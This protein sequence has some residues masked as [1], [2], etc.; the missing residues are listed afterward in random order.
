MGQEV[1]TGKEIHFELICSL[2]WVICYTTPMNKIF[3]TVPIP[4]TDFFLIGGVSSVG[5]CVEEG[6][7]FFAR[8][9]ANKKKRER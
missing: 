5:L 8:R 1:G 6:R 7:K 9:I 4:M 2:R 3:H